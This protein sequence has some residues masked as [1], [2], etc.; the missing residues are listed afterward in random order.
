LILG[1]F[2]PPAIAGA[3]EFVQELPLESLP[4]K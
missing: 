4:Q 1:W 3:T 2:D